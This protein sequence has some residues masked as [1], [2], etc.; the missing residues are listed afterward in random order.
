MFSTK[1]KKIKQI[2]IYRESHLPEKGWL[3]S[4]FQCYEITSKI[5]L[6]D[7][8]K[9]DNNR[10]AYWELYIYMCPKCKRELKYNKKKY[11]LFFNSYKKY[12]FE[13]YPQLYELI[14]LKQIN[15]SAI[16][17]Q[18]WWKKKYESMQDIVL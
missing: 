12:I 13:N 1:K 9:T 6:F 4:C 10:I 18:K 5:K 17:I 2:H 11:K 16:I 14:E 15:R 7:I 3:Q 8:Y